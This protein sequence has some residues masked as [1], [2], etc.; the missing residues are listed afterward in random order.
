MPVNCTLWNHTQ[1]PY[2]MF[3]LLVQNPRIPKTKM[4]K[5]LKINP[6]TLRIWYDEAVQKRIIILPILRR[7]SF[8]NFKEYIYFLNVKQPHYYYKELQELENITYFCVQTGFS[9]FQL[10]SKVPLPQFEQYS[11]LKGHRSDYYVTI[12]P[13][14]SFVE[15]ISR[16][17]EKMENLDDFRWKPSPLK[18]HLE[19]YEPWDEIDERTYWMVTD[20][21][22]KPF[23]EIIREGQTYS[24][25]VLEFFRNKDRF[26]EVFSMYFP[27]GEGS[28]QPSLFSIKTDNDALLIDLFSCFPMSNVFYRLDNRLIMWIN[29]PFLLD[30]RILVREVLLNLKKEELVEE[31]SNSIVEYSYRF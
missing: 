16:I 19:S 6:D 11:V 18:F 27:D 29:L 20:N 15:S 25:R 31:Y 21:I 10:I 7:N 23:R 14:C 28:Y 22:R 8:A 5:A 4:A 13:E 1:S 26:G 12:P 3:E 17:K 24:D 9:N 30:A 2:K